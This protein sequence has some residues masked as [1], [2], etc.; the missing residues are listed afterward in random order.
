M[1][2]WQEIDTT[3]EATPFNTPF[4][5]LDTELTSFRVFPPIFLYIFLPIFALRTKTYVCKNK[6]VKKDEKKT[7]QSQT[8][9][10]VTTKN[11]KQRRRNVDFAFGIS[12]KNIKSLSDIA[13]PIYY[14]IECQIGLGQC[15]KFGIHDGFDMSHKFCYIKQIF[16]RRNTRR[17]KSNKLT[18]K[19]SIK[20]I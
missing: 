7:H 10:K 14:I 11:R 3:M 2:F 9:A 16:D 19:M 18:T 8:S 6:F 17:K 5:P 20:C 4:I 13:T 15:I 12:T 1:K